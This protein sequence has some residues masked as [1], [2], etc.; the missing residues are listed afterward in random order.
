MLME[1]TEKC[2]E[3]FNKCIRL[4]PDFEQPEI[5]LCYAMYRAAA[6]ARDIVKVNQSFEKFKQVLKKFPKSSDG[7]AMYAQALADSGHTTESL[8]T[9]DKAISLCPENAA[10]YVHKG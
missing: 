8:Q 1:D 4:N 7:H 3:E 9:F 10:N 2:I 6:N 5:Q